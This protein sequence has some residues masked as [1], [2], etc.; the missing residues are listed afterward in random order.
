MALPSAT[1][2]TTTPESRSSGETKSAS[3]EATEPPQIRLATGGP[4]TNGVG[5]GGGDGHRRQ[6]PWADDGR[7]EGKAQA[8]LTPAQSS[9]SASFRDRPRLPR[10]RSQSH[11]TSQSIAA[12]RGNGDRLQLQWKDG[13]E[14]WKDGKEDRHRIKR[15]EARVDSMHGLLE[16]I[17]RSVASLQQPPSQQHHQQQQQQQQQQQSQQQ[18]QPP[19]QDSSRTSARCDGGPTVV[20]RT[21]NKKKSLPTED[22]GVHVGA[23]GGRAPTPPHDAVGLL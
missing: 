18:P 1:T 11:S 16:G 15:L 17:A 4:S 6:L 5:D 2:R 20:T 10:R 12:A 21:G 7:A 14:Q 19:P 23:A 13:T 22:W 8:P 9:I 3:V